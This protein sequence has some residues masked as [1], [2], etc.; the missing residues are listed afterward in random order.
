[1]SNFSKIK[2]SAIF[3]KELVTGYLPDIDYERIKKFPTAIT[4]YKKVKLFGTKEELIFLEYDY[5]DGSSA[6]YP[7]KYQLLF[8]FKGN[9]IKIFSALRF[10][11]LKIF[12]KENPFLVTLISTSRGN[13]GHQ[14][15]KMSAD[16]LEN[17]Y[18]GYLDYET[19]TYDREENNIVFE[20]FELNLQV[21]DEN[22]DGINDIVFTGKLVLI[23]GVTKSGVWYDYEIRNGD[24]ISYS[25]NNPFKKVPVKFVFLY[26]KKTGHFSEMENYKVKY[27]QYKQ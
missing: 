14:I 12:P 23:Q 10:Q 11:F 18:D 8:D 6:E 7:W 20:P 16:T 25:I 19:Q 26:N 3:I 17:V 22:K 24:T 27:K 15:F 1:M 4:C 2:D 21:K 13:G 9:C 5:K